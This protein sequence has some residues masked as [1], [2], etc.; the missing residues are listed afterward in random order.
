M[1]SSTTSIKGTV[2]AKHGARSAAWEGPNM[3]IVLFVLSLGIGVLV[4]LGASNLASPPSGHSS[5]GSAAPV[6]RAAAQLGYTSERAF[7]ADNERA[8]DALLQ[9]LQAPAGTQRLWE[10]AETG[11]RGVI[12]SGAETRSAG[13]TIC[14]ELERRTLINNAYR[15]ANA[16]ACREQGKAW[17]GEAGW[18]NE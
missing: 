10:N 9:V 7:Q 13:G 8:S 5:A 16:T 2:S 11:N 6:T 4:G 12:W 15:N 18:R 3:V 14:R 17:K 1:F